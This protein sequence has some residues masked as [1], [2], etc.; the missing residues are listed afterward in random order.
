MAG[1]GGGR[2]PQVERLDVVPEPA[3][4]EDV[5]GDG[6]GAGDVGSPGARVLLQAGDERRARA[7]HDV[8]RDAR[9]DDLP[10]QP[11]R[12]QAGA[13]ALGQRAGK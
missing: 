9:G 8:V 12:P 3:Q 13:E 6:V 5:P 10:A 11:V 1:L 2:D 4:P 7:V